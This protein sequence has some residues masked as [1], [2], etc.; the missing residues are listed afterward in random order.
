MADIIKKDPQTSSGITLNKGKLRSTASG[1]QARVK[2]SQAETVDPAT[3][4][5]RITLMLDKSGSMN[6]YEKDSKRRIDLLKDAIENF[7]GRCN[8]NDTSV[9]I[10]TF[11]PSIAVP[12][13]SNRTILTSASYGLS[14]SGNTPM[15]NCV[16]SCLNKIPMTRGVIVS[17]GAATDWHVY[18][19]YDY[20][21][22]EGMGSADEILAKYKEAGIPIDCVHISLGTSGEELLRRIAATTGGIFIK[23]TDVSAFAQAFGYL[24]PGFRA[25]LTDG[26]VSASDLGARE[27]DAR[28]NS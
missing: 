2:K 4:P 25:M 27:L 22:E 23:F 15:R 24:A 26:R 10:E 7:V 21:R 9:A 17:D 19:K 18:D 8:L 16:E 5:N 13:T 11:P 28:P 3:M 12:L 6:D 20:M 14:A 1:F